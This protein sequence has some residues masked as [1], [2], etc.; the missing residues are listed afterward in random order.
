ML[1][2]LRCECLIHFVFFV[3]VFLRKPRDN[4]SLL[5]LKQIC[6]IGPVENVSIF[7]EICIVSIGE[8]FSEKGRQLVL[9]NTMSDI[10]KQILITFQVELLMGKQTF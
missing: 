2:I 6:S 10:I 4:K 3:F 5:S 8:R 7:S 9:Y 1:I